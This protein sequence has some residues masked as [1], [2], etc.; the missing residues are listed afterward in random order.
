M[1]VSLGTQPVALVYHFGR[2]LC[3]DP[4]TSSA[5]KHV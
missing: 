2:G 4:Q 3:L 5:S 1:I